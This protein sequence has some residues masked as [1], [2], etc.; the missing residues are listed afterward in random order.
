MAMQRHSVVLRFLAAKVWRQLASAT[1]SGIEASPG[2]F[3]V[4]ASETNLTVTNA[5]GVLHSH[6]EGEGED[7]ERFAD[8]DLSELSLNVCKGLQVIGQ[9]LQST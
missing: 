2:G 5:R 1:S 6:F 7:D 3:G 9:L 4:V 8:L